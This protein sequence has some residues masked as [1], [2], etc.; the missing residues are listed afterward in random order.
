MVRRRRYSKQTQFNGGIPYG[1]G[2]LNKEKIIEDLEGRKTEPSFKVNEIGDDDPTIHAIAYLQKVGWLQ[3]HDKALT[4]LNNC[5]DE[6][7][8][9]GNE[10]NCMMTI[11]GECSYA[12]TGCGD[13]AIVEKVR[14]ALDKYEPKTEPQTEYKKWEIKPAADLSVVN[15]TCVGVAMALVEGEPQ[16]E[17]DYPKNCPYNCNWDE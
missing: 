6:P 4:E 1:K 15:T 10:H 12:E 17:E 2:W 9:Y 14:K 7:Q 11:F 5:E 13:C 3:E 8:I 16:T